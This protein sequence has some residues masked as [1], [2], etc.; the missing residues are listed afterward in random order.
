M[1]TPSFLQGAIEVSTR[2]ALVL[3]AI[4]LV[5]VCLVV[6]WRLASP[7]VVMHYAADAKAPVLVLYD[8]GRFKGRDYVRP[9]SALTYHEDMFS[10]A[11]RFIMVTVPDGAGY[12]D[13][14]FAFSRIDI[15]I[16]A[17]HDIKRVEVKQDFLTRFN[18]A[19]G[20]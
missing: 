8:S 6:A 7:V 17:N 13:I 18:P 14:D 19:W 9:G 20:K 10:D 2:L 15:Y 1:K 5:L 16:D 12:Y 4:A 3:L 11:Q